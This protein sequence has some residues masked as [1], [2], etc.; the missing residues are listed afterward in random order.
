MYPLCPVVSMRKYSPSPGSNESQFISV[1]G[2]TTKPTPYYPY[3][4]LPQ[5]IIFDANTC[6]LDSPARDSSV[7]DDQPDIY[8]KVTT[9][10]Q[11][12]KVRPD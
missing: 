7:D 1:F 6:S 12:Y 3:F 10:Q 9:A 5:Y 4:S 8:M 11:T 2:R